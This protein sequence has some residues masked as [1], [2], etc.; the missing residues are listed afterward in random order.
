MR[1]LALAANPLSILTQVRIGEPLSAW[2]AGQDG[3]LRLRPLHDVPMDELA[4]SDVVVVERGM[5][6]R[7]LNLMQQAAAMGRAVIYEIDDLL[8]EPAPHLQ[9]AEAL[10]RGARWVRASLQAADVVTLSTER[11]R[12]LLEL[13][14]EQGVVVPNAAFD[15]PIALQPALQQAGRVTLLVAASDRMDGGD[16]W[17][18]LK[19]VASSRGDAVT[20]LAVGPVADDLAQAG[21]PCQRFPL[22]PRQAFLAWAA[23]QANP[24]GLIPLDGSRF[25]AGKSAIKWFDYALAGVATL[26]SNVA[27]Y[28]DV[29]E[30]D[31]TGWLVGPSFAAWHSA[32]E[33]AIDGATRRAQ[34]AAAARQHVL[35]HH[36]VRFMRQ[37]WGHA[38]R[39]AA[40]R[41]AR[42]GVALT[43]SP[44]LRLRGA[45]QSLELWL[46]RWN[47]E[48]LAQRK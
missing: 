20:V 35:E 33:V 7:H 46:R 15:G 39:M 34:V 24:I 45:V 41:A 32:L 14:P 29:I 25:S 18:A 26:A 11:L 23:T 5:S 8:T 43:P 16:A 40:D 1:V 38:L 28:S 31:R 6:R 47:R 42:R 4:W 10:R 22:M 13:A 3:E 27:P 9:H 30:N 12:S 48:R 2:L 21:V 17:R 19:A 36:H 37:A 44:F